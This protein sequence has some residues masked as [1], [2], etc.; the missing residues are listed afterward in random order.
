MVGRIIHYCPLV[1]AGRF[2]LHHLVRVNGKIGGRGDLVPLDDGVKRQLQ[3]WLVLLNA[4]SGLAAIPAVR[5][6]A[7]AWAREYFTDAVGGSTGYVGAG[8]GGVSMDW[9][10]YLPWGR[11]IN[12]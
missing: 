5:V 6:V 8:C 1:A 7:P 9:W 10:F 4:M 2:N 3:F 12:S 11:K